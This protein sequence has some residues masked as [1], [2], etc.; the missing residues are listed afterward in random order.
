MTAE[1]IPFNMVHA[2]IWRASPT[3]ST[4]F[5]ITLSDSD[6]HSSSESSHP[7]EPED[8]TTT[9]LVGENTPGKLTS[10]EIEILH[11]N[12]KE[13]KALK[14]DRRKPVNRRVQDL[15]RH[16]PANEYI[17]GEDWKAKLGV[18]H[19]VFCSAKANIL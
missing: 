16:L 5:T 8:P 17:L 3:K 18:G 12:L 9:G 1:G 13:W 7:T 14:G 19:V 11:A 4:T 2:M 10:E 15:I 6:S